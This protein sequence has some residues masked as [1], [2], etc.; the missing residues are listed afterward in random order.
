MKMASKLCYLFVFAGC[1][2]A[3]ATTVEDN[4]RLSATPAPYAAS[5][6]CPATARQL[7]EK[8][9]PSGVPLGDAAVALYKA[10][11]IGAG[12]Q[13]PDLQTALRD[14]CHSIQ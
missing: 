10:A 6:T 5:T 7:T 9:Q 2:V 4:I 13:P 8:K 1:R 12:S 3:S 11:K 14:N